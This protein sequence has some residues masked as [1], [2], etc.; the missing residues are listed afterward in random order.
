M[1]FYGTLILPWLSSVVVLVCAGHLIL[2]FLCSTSVISLHISFDLN[3]PKTYWVGQ[4]RI[5]RAF[6][7]VTAQ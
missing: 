4:T 2:L 3:A 5:N 6:K 1:S 7:P